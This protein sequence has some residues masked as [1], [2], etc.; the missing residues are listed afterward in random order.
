MKKN[1]KDVIVSRYI[2]DP[3]LING[4]KFDLRIYIAITSVDPLRIYFYEEGLARFATEKFTLSSGEVP[5]RFVH[6]TNF[7]INKHSDNYHIDEH[8]E[9][10][11]CKWSLATLKVNFCM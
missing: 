4:F 1:T 11:G 9:T 7:S 10:E 8:N 6:L 2:A 3:L 5:N